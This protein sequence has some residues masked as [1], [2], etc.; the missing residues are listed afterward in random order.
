MVEAAFSVV[1]V[2]AA[3]LFAASSVSHMAAAWILRD[4]FN[5]ATRYACT[6]WI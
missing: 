2:T 4:D 5:V 6:V 3:A 1:V